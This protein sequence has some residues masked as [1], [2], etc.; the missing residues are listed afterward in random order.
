[1]KAGCNYY[2][3]REYFIYTGLIFVKHCWGLANI[4][5]CIGELLCVRDYHRKKFAELDLYGVPLIIVGLG[6]TYSVAKAFEFAWLFS[7]INGSKAFRTYQDKHRGAVYTSYNFSEVIVKKAY[8]K[9]SFSPQPIPLKNTVKF[10][11]QTCGF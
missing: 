10:A 8:K 11:E 9:D 7:A 6:G 2:T 3:N 5:L 1:M 4:I